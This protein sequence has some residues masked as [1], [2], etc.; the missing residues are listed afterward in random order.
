MTKQ[1]TTKYIAQNAVVAAVYFILTII[2]APYSYLGIQFRIAELLVLLCFWR[3]DFIIGVTLGCFLANTLSSLGPWDMLFGTLATLVSA[4]LV[5]YASPRL[6]ISIIYPT[7]V[8]AFVV[9]A[10]L[11]FILGE[12]FWVQVGLVAIGEGAVM[13][14][15]Y[16]IWLILSR[17]KGLMNFLAPTRHQD[18][19]Y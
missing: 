1:I 19:R 16:L 14:V 13:I 10:E 2:L 3:P 5:A 8:N 17:N 15:S 11:Y 6:F 4:L 9:G 12:A 18:I 7:A